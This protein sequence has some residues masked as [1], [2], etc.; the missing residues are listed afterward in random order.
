MLHINES[1]SVFQA[2]RKSLSLAALAAM[3]L[4]EKRSEA[5][6]ETVDYITA[7]ILK[8]TV[9]YTSKTKAKAYTQNK[10]RNVSSSGLLMVAVG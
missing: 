9:R 7:V 3:P 1:Y 6:K 2:L 4:G 8:S 5:W 10:A